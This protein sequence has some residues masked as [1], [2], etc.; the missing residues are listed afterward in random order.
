MKDIYFVTSIRTLSTKNGDIIS[1]SNVV[2]AAYENKNSAI[3]RA[4]KYG[5]YLI[6]TYH[7][8]TDDSMRKSLSDFDDL[9]VYECVTLGKR[10][11]I[12]EDGEYISTVEH[13]IEIEEITLFE[14]GEGI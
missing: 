2:I 7:L 1:E 9:D 3:D 8:K 14:N 4:K 12:N 6:K 11:K 10:D 13:S 5:E